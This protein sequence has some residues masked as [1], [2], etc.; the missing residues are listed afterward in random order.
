MSD[1]LG[2]ELDQLSRLGG[3][4]LAGRIRLVTAGSRDI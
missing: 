2:T 4:V 3:D 1:W